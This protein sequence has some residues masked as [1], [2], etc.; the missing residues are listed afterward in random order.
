M[1]TPLDLSAAGEVKVTLDIPSVGWQAAFIE[2][3]FKDGFVATTPVY[4]LPKDK[5]PSTII[6][7]AHNGLLCKFLHGR[8]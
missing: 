8:T 2:A 3:T 5:Y 1:E 6:P 4:I 7:P